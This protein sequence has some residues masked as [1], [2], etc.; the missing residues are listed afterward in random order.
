M[1]KQRPDLPIVVRV[2]YMSDRDALAGLGA[3]EV[4]W[5]E[6]EAGEEIADRALKR[7]SIG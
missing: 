6:Q 3:D 1:K 4:V 7:L 2:R 5:E